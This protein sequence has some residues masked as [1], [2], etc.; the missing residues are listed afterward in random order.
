MR[1]IAASVIL[2]AL[3]TLYIEPEL[4]EPVYLSPVELNR[5][6]DKIHSRDVALRAYELAHYEL[7][8]SLSSVF[9]D[10][11]MSRFTHEIDLLTG[12]FYPCDPCNTG[13]PPTFLN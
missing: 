12:E 4:D 7:D 3:G 10:H 13:I 11:G 9:E 8:V 2:A 6:V 5:L 1:I